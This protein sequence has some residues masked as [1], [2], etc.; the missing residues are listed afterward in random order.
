MH[1]PLKTPGFV[2]SPELGTL[3][4]ITVDQATQQHYFVTGNKKRRRQPAHVGDICRCTILYPLSLSTLCSQWFLT[5]THH[6]LTIPFR[7][8]D[9]LATPFT[10]RSP[11]GRR[12]ASAV[13]PPRWR[14]AKWPAVH[15]MDCF[16]MI[17]S[18][19]Q[20]VWPVEIS[21]DQLRSVELSWD[22]C[23][24]DSTV[25]S[26]LLCNTIIEQHVAHLASI[27]RLRQITASSCLNGQFG[28]VV[29]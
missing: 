25:P 14:C 9:S 15:R 7:W 6:V 23:F 5:N 20:A 2:P 22:L 13:H 12:L 4:R 1:A 10:V 26:L 3:K 16:R 29:C 18:T 8:H 19:L 11:T 28:K 21:W 24:P 17:E 27:S